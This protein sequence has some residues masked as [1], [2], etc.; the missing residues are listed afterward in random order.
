MI[1]KRWGMAFIGILTAVLILLGTLIPISPLRELRLLL[2]QWTMI[3]AVF[4]FILAFLHLIRVNLARIKPNKHQGLM[5]ILTVVSALT[6][7]GI[8]YTQGPEG[9]YSQFLLNALLIPGE[10]ALMGLLSITL[11]L[12]GIRMAQVRPLGE[13]AVFVIVVV[14]MLIGTIPVLGLLGSVALWIQKVPAM[15]GLRGLVLGVALGVILAGL[16]FFAG[17]DRPQS[18]E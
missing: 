15:A 3:I 4:A 18:E 14:I 11:L 8:V 13:V 10:A 7:L 2:L 16:R 6:T 1:L 12:A 5:G 9:V 17:V